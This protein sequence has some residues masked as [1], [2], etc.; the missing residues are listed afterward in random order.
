MFVVNDDM[1]IYI[2]R[3]DEAQFTVSAT[4][5]GTT[6]HVFEAGDVIRFKVFEKKACENVVL[7]KD[8]GITESTEAVTIHLTED[9]TRF[10]EIISK[11]KDYWFE[12]ELNPE[13]APQTILGYDDDGPKIFRLFPEG[14]DLEHTPIEPEDIPVVDKDLSLTSARP[15]ENRAVTRAILQLTDELEKTQDDTEN[16]LKETKSAINEQAEATENV[17]Q[18]VAVE[19]A[20]IDALVTDG[21]GNTT[22]EY[23]LRDKEDFKIK[24]ITNGAIAIFIAYGSFPTTSGETLTIGT[25]PTELEPLRSIPSIDKNGVLFDFVEIIFNDGLENEYKEWEIKYS[26]EAEVSGT[27]DCSYPIKSS[28]IPELIDV[29]IDAFGETH[30]SAGASV[31]SQVNAL[32]RQCQEILSPER[33][34]ALDNMFRVCAYIKDDVSAEY[35]AFKTAFGIGES[36]GG[37]E[38]E[39]ET[40]VPATAITLSETTLTFTDTESQTIEVTVEP[41]NTTD[42]VVWSSDD[43]SVAM[44]TGGTVK[45]LSNGSAIITATA[46][47]VSAICNV[48]VNIV[49]EEEVVLTGIT[50]TYTGGDVPVGTAVTSLSGVTVKGHFSDGSSQT[51]RTS[52][53]RLS[54]TIAEGE[55]TITVTYKEFTTTFTVV[56][57]AESTD[58]GTDEGTEEKT[59]TLEY[60]DLTSVQVALWMDSSTATAFNVENAD[61]VEIVDGAITLVNPVTTTLYKTTSENYSLNDYSALYGKYITT[62]THYYYIEADSSYSHPYDV[63]GIVDEYINYT[64]ARKL[65][66]V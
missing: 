58:E 49:E 21:S 60:G 36:D 16:A 55:N 52:A 23:I 39:E 3:G 33:L 5:G 2:T 31:R 30:G 28:Y 32:I 45:P 42:A 53:Y 27:M 37:S 14:K 62:G 41:Y 63:D 48:T 46:G 7:Q 38:E 47:N 12:I 65:T 22:T 26:A 8:F 43:D 35:G 56:G 40:T 15:V 10:G 17:A 25:L 1:S 59:Y 44:V 57:V 50:A 6:V 4:D 20:R 34:S 9:E 29:R 54:G 19:R 51:V 66:V 11:P 24:I 18:E 61:T 13:S 64:S